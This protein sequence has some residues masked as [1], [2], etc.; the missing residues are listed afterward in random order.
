[1]ESINLAQ[2]SENSPLELSSGLMG[3]LFSN[4]KGMSI[5][6]AIILVL[7][8]GVIVYI[9]YK[10]IK[11]R[12]SVNSEKKSLKNDLM[13]WSNLSD[14]VSGGK[15]TQAGKEQLNGEFS[16]IKAI[17]MSA[18]LFIKRKCFKKEL[19]PWYILLGEPLSGKT[20]L[21]KT[22]ALDYEQAIEN[23]TTSDDILQFYVNQQRV[24][25]DVNGKVFFDHWLGGGSAKWSIITHLIYKLHKHKPLSGILLT[26]PADALIADEAKLTQKKANL[27]AHELATL[28]HS[29]KM[30]LPCRILIT[31]ADCILG[32]R[33]YFAQLPKEL[34]EQALGFQFEVEIELGATEQLRLKWDEFIAKI[35]YGSKSI[36]GENSV[37]NSNLSMMNRLEKT[38]YIQLFPQ[39]LNRLYENLKTYVIALQ[40]KNNLSVAI[41]LEG[42]FFTSFKDLGLNFCQDFAQYQNKKIDEALMHA[43]DV[44]STEPLFISHILSNCFAPLNRLATFTKA[45]IRRRNLPKVVFCTALALISLNYFIASLSSQYLI[46]DKLSIEVRYLK[47]LDDMFINSRL[48]KSPLFET[49]D[50]GKGVRKFNDLMFSEQKISRFNYFSDARETLLAPQNLSFIY[51]PANYLFFDFNDLGQDKRRTIYNEVIFDMVLR[52]TTEGFSK[53][54]LQNEEPFTEAKAD[55]LFSY[56]YLS[57][58]KFRSFKDIDYHALILDSIDN[59]LSYQYPVVAKEVKKMLGSLAKGDENFTKAAVSQILLNP[60]YVPSIDKGLTL[61]N[62]Q[63]K[64]LEAYPESKYQTASLVLNLGSE[65]QQNCTKLED[66]TYIFDAQGNFKQDLALYSSWQELIKRSQAITA[67]LND[68]KTSF[69]LDYSLPIQEKNQDENKGIF[70]HRD[71]I[72]EEA[73]EGYKS[74]LKNDFDVFL[75]YAKSRGDMVNSFAD[76]FTVEQIKLDKDVALANL[77]QNYELLKGVAK[78]L[79]KTSIFE[80]FDTQSGIV[81]QYQVLSELFNII[82][83]E[84]NEFDKLN[85]RISF[86]AK[87]EQL[88]SEYKNRAEE[89]NN[90]IKTYEKLPSI[91]NLARSCNKLLKFNEFIV[92]TKLTEEFLAQYPHDKSQVKNVIMLQHLAASLKHVED[93]LFSEEL[94]TEALGVVEVVP[95][96]NPQAVIEFI[97]PLAFLVQL[98]QGKGNKVSDVDSNF[99]QYLKANENF[100]IVKTAYST[101]LDGFVNYW[102]NFADELKP[103]A[104]DYYTFHDFSQRSRAYQINAQLLDIYNFSY[105]LLASFNTKPMWHKTKELLTTALNKLDLKRRSLTLEFNDVCANVLNSWA[106][107]PKDPVKANHYISALNKKDVRKN[108]TLVKNLK[109]AKGNIPWWSAYIDLGSALL[110]S[111]ASYETA[112]GLEQF[113]SRLY[114]FPILKDARVGDL[115]IQPKD[116][117]I[118]LKQLKSYALITNNS[119]S[120]VRSEKQAQA[121]DETTDYLQEPLLE[122]VMV[123]NINLVSWLNNVTRILSVFADTT[124]PL[125]VTVSIPSSDKQ[126]SLINE[127]GIKGVTALNKFRFVETSIGGAEPKRVASFVANDKDVVL[128][129]DMASKSNLSFKFYRYSDDKIAQSEVNFDGG[130]SALRLYLA[131]QGIYDDKDKCVYVPLT[132]TDLNLNKSVFIVKISFNKELVAPIDWPSS[133]TWPSIN[134]F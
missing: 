52:P 7:I 11:H 112:Y 51:F 70:T 96:Y 108:F 105:E 125:L 126:Q 41:S 63:L 66:F 53:N 46:K 79:D 10:R 2:T 27:M 82:Y 8:I 127:H 84:H 35:K 88:S 111:E 77:E 116:M 39:E 36:L 3:G 29:V 49:D 62:K 54:L 18:L 68:Y 98:E 76:S 100:Q 33:E 31:K 6:V 130:Y 9:L 131:E 23:H 114:Y 42:V 90:F 22:S 14:L 12:L 121:S 1:M 122:N 103:M 94:A 115:T 101:Y 15:K 80:R 89:L 65:L 40:S 87:F 30:N 110:K 99:A 97:N 16:V 32:F 48:K 38:S 44:M 132:L 20:S 133:N 78:E 73:Y 37:L 129:K 13:I 107:L 128:V 26:I 50:T 57:L 72:L 86:E 69:L 60:N 102:A 81:L 64:N 91:A 28:V 24:I 34:K 109:D 92:K 56:I 61:L 93:S 67:T 123:G 85:D 95:Q 47:A 117:S 106:L 75:K 104:S 55:A 118:L 4:P 124:S 59:I 119:D 134:D 120:S 58:I 45:E 83:V 71:L 17:F 113:Q 43:Q 25:L 21:L 5:I 19:A 74:I